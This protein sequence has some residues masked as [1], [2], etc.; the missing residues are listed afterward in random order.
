MKLLV[1]SA[2]YPA[3]GLRGDQSR[4]ASHLD[5]LGRRHEITVLTTEPPPSAA[6]GR[7]LEAIAQV[8][9]IRVGRGER[10]T[11][12][13]RFASSGR[14]AQTGWMMPPRPWRVAARLA[15]NFEVALINTTR[16]IRGPL[17]AP[18]VIDHIDALSYNMAQRARGPERWP[19]RS[20][21]RSEAAAFRRWERSV[22]G[23]SR[24]QLGASQEVLKMLPSSPAPILLPTGW[25]GEVFVDPPGHRR[26]IDVI[27]TGDMSYPPNRQAAQWLAAE[28]LPR[29]L[30][31]R[32]N[33]TAW[34]VGRH[35]DRVSFRGI[36]TAANVPDLHAF[37]RRAKVALVPVKGAGSPFK[38]IE[39]AAN[40]AAVVGFAWT[41][42]CYGMAA[43]VASTADEFA[44]GAL[45][46]LESEDLRCRQVHAAR[47]AVLRHSSEEL[48]SRLE[49]ILE[50][51]A[52]GTRSEHVQVGR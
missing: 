16:S 14:P 8:E 48:A 15:P 1:V 24:A 52:F 43:T 20:V 37:L 32:S 51:A 38:T 10:A 2:R 17:E 36:K 34:I 46:L 40:G 44:A 30:E 26:D 31:R 45:G 12:A 23:W 5:R 41:V 39:A 6:V 3:A 22:A 42:E 13:A 49:A 29:M 27:L 25:D 7:R 18:L 21:A 35:A 47:P 50:E 11:S 9:V 33:T 4:L 28:I 19:R